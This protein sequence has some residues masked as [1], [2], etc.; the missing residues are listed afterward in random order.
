MMARLD[1]LNKEAIAA[2]N[3]AVSSTGLSSE[4]QT[5][6]DKTLAA[7]AD[8]ERAVHDALAKIDRRKYPPMYRNEVS[9]SNAVPLSDGQFIYWVC[10][11][12]MKGPG[13]HVIACFNL[14]GHGEGVVGKPR[15][16]SHVRH[17]GHS[18]HR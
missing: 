8:T 9:S 15:C 2:I 16:E 13:S 17:A 5:E 4:Q 6:L 10:G 14:A 12:G 1:A 3:A 11:G 7:K 18:P